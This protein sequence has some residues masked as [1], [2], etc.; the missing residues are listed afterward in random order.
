MNGQGA[1]MG[2]AFLSLNRSATG[3]YRQNR[4]AA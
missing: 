2:C 4:N 3:N 1:Q